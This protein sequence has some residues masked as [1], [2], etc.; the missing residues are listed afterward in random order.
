MI[1]TGR[2]INGQFEKRPFLLYINE[3]K[4]DLKFPPTVGWKSFAHKCSCAHHPTGLMPGEGNVCIQYVSRTPADPNLPEYMF[5]VKHNDRRIHL[6]YAR[7]KWALNGKPVYSST[8]FRIS[9]IDIMH[10]GKHWEIIEHEM[11]TNR[12]YVIYL[13]DKSPDS[14][15]PP[16]DQWVRGTFP[17]DLKKGG[18]PI[19]MRKHSANWVS[20]LR[21]IPVS[22]GLMRSGVIPTDETGGT[23]SRKYRRV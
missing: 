21:V 17:K 13:D 10:N 1:S 8:Q 16:V 7:Q 11:K 18:E 23:S 19:L 3:A 9:R 6:N 12:C 15:V 22:E 14:D 4:D 5:V 2:I 20:D